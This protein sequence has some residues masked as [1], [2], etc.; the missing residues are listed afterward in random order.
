[1]TGFKHEKAS[2]AGNARIVKVQP[3][4]KLDTLE[5]LLENEVISQA[6]FNLVRDALSSKS[7]PKKEVITKQQKL[8]ETLD[9]LRVTQVPTKVGGI[10]LIDGND[11]FAYRI[12]DQDTVVPLPLKLKNNK[13]DYDPT[14]TNGIEKK[15]VTGYLIDDSYIS[16]EQIEPIQ[17]LGVDI[18][19]ELDEVYEDTAK[20]LSQEE[21]KG[22]DIRLTLTELATKLKEKSGTTSENLD[23][24]LG[25][26]KINDNLRNILQWRLGK[27]IKIEC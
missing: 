24:F 20:E 17:E 23:K 4:V 10:Y 19:G 9:K 8:K 21:D 6:E 13:L 7:K 15:I 2:Q 12:V 27:G 14:L 22:V 25:E 1:M 16:E 5:S 11:Q 26:E 18:R 3:E